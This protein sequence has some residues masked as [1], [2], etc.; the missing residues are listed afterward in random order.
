MKEKQIEVNNMEE[1][2][3]Q[4]NYEEINVMDSRN[5]DDFIESREK[6][7]AFTMKIILL[8]MTYWHVTSAVLKWS[9]LVVWKYT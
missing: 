9:P 6:K 5:N 1:V 7:L 4:G 3:Y 8:K 2:D